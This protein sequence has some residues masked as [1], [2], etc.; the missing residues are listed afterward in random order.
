MKGKDKPTDP[1][2]KDYVRP[3]MSLEEVTRLKECFDIF[4][5]DGSGSISPEELRNAIVALGM[6]QQAQKILSLVGAYTRNC[7]SDDIDF[8]A[9]MELFGFN[10]DLKDK[11][12]Q[13]N[14]VKQFDS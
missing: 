8:G 3:G 10:S 13:E 12:S 4:D 9:F 1:S 5:S 11:S 6:E 2:L 7:G 14:I